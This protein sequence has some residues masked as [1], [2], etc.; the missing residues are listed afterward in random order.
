MLPDMDDVMPL[1]EV[2]PPDMPADLPALPLFEDPGPIAGNVSYRLW[3]GSL[4]QTFSFSPSDF[5]V[6]GRTTFH[7]PH[8]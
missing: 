5:L 1:P 8:L 4:A 6:A 7:L 2:L 3:E